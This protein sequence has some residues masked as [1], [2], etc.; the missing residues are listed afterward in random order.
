MPYSTV[1]FDLYGTLVAG[2]SFTGHER[3]V[4][5]MAE[6]LRA[7]DPAA[8]AQIFTYETWLDRSTGRV[9]TIQ[10]NI[11]A[12]F[13]RLG[14]PFEPER[15]ADVVHLRRAFTAEAMTPLPGAVEAVE[16]VRARGYCIGLISDCAEETP[17]LWNQT[18]FAPLIEVAIFS[19]E[20]GML[21]PNPGIYTLAC[22]RL[23]AE[24]AAC[25]YVGDREEELIGAR[26]VGMYTVQS[27]PP[28]LDTYE[29]RDANRP[30][31]DGPVIPSVAALPA[32]L[33]ALDA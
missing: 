21:K 18:P 5:Q 26:G 3:V 23:G 4:A 28:H 33:D 19:C 25:V 30:S 27:L 11:E 22:Q 16:A 9:P 17:L 14:W 31:W 10:A 2:Y 29:S 7:P 32:L 12:I 13:Q 24:P 15:I 20:V 8:F 1:I 6:M